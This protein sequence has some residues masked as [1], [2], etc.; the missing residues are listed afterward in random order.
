[1][2]EVFIVAK[3]PSIAPNSVPSIAKN[4]IFLFIYQKQE[5]VFEKKIKM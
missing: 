3:P 4:K 1:M 2:N 5:T